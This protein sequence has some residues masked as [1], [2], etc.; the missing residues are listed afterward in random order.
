VH[1]TIRRLAAAFGLAAGTA[2]ALPAL[3]A[4]DPAAMCRAAAE[5]A[6]R[7]TG[8][9]L[10]VLMAVALTE[11]ARRHEGGVVPWPWTMNLAGDGRWFDNRS[12]ALAAARAARDSGEARFDLGCFQINYRWHGHRFASLEA[13][14]DPAANALYAA[15]FLARLHAET[16]DWTRAAGHYHSRTPHHAARYRRA[17]S[18]HLAALGEA[19]LAPAPAVARSEPQ[20]T[21]G[22]SLLKAG[23]PPVAMGSLVPRQEGRGALLARNAG[24]LWAR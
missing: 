13:M 17:F 21:N 8:V 24:S 23:A 20:R 16:G 18:G 10:R 3:P 22:F 15:R 14:L 1:A 2:T 6:A 9:P 12:A 11:S 4:T 19:P 5:D 7:T